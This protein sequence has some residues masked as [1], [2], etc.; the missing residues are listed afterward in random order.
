MQTEANAGSVLDALRP[1]PTYAA[2][3]VAP[4]SASLPTAD[5]VLEAQQSGGVAGVLLAQLMMWWMNGYDYPMWV[6]GKEP[7]AW[8]PTIPI[9]FELMVLL[10][11][12]GNLGGLTEA[13]EM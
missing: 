9:T 6:S 11:S 13:M 4:P 8:P 3:L 1:S 7:Y 12:F 5:I 10:A 2:L